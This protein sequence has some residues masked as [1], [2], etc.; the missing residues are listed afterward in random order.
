[1]A[2]TSE[3]L[4][5]ASMEVMFDA[6]EAFTVG[7][8]PL[9]RLQKKLKSQ[10]E[11][12][13]GKKNI[14]KINFCTNGYCTDAVLWL[15]GNTLPM[16]AIATLSEIN[17]LGCGLITDVGISWITKFLRTN[18]HTLIKLDGC[19]KITDA[20]LALLKTA[21][22]LAQISAMATSVTHLRQHGYTKGC[23][24]L[25][26]HESYDRETRRNAQVLIIPYKTQAS[27]AVYLKNQ[28]ITPRQHL[29]RI[30][31]AIVKDWHLNL[32]EIDSVNPLF[33]NL[34]SPNLVQVIIPFDANC[35][36]PEIR[37]HIGDTISLVL[38]KERLNPVHPHLKVQQNNNFF[39]VYMYHKCILT[40]DGI[41][42]SLTNTESVIGMVTSRQPLSRSHPYFEVECLTV[43]SEE[44]TGVVIGVIFDVL[45][46][47]RFPME[48][49]ETN[50][51]AVEGFQL[52]AGV[53]F[54]FGVEGD[55]QSEYV[56]KEDAEFYWTK[57]GV[58]MTEKSVSEKPHIGMYPMLSVLGSQTGEVKILN[59]ASLPEEILADYGRNKQYWSCLF[60][61]NILHD[62]DGILS[63]RDNYASLNDVGLFICNREIT[64]R[65]NSCTIEIL[66]TGT[67]GTITLGIGPEDYKVNRQ[68][69]W[70]SN[71][72]ALH[73]D[74]GQVYRGSGGSSISPPG[75]EF[76]WK[77]GDK[78]T[79]TVTNF[80]GEQIIAS[81]KPTVEFS[82]NGN[83]SPM[84][85]KVTMGRSH[86]INPMDDGLLAYRSFD[87][88][89]FYGL[90]VSKTPISQHLPFF[91]IEVLKCNDRQHIG[92]GLC[93][94]YYPSNEMI[95]WKQGSVGYHAD[96]GKLYH[97]TST[98]YASTITR[99][100]TSYKAGD[101]IRCEVDFMKARVKPDGTLY[102]QQ[103]ISVW[104]YKNGVKTHECDFEYLTEGLY[105]AINLHFEGDQ[106]KLHNYYPG[107]ESQFS[108]LDKEETNAA[109]PKYSF[110]EGCHF[111][112]VGMGSDSADA[113]G[114]IQLISQL[115]NP[116]TD[117]PAISSLQ[118][119]IDQLKCHLGSLDLQAQERY[120]QLLWQLEC[121]QRF[122]KNHQRL[123]FMSLNLSSHEGVNEIKDHIVSHL[124]S[125]LR[126]HTRFYELEETTWKYLDNICSILKEKNILLAEDLHELVPKSSISGN[127]RMFEQAV[128]F[129][130]KKGLVLCLPMKNSLVVLDF[131]FVL[132]LTTS[133]EQCQKKEPSHSVPCIGVGATI[134][135][136]ELQ[137]CE[138]VQELDEHRVRLLRWILQ[139]FGVLRIPSIRVST[140][141]PMYLFF[142]L[143]SIGRTSLT[144]NDFMCHEQDKKNVVVMRR[145]YRFIHTLGKSLFAFILTR[146]ARFSH[147]VLICHDGGVFQ[148]GAVQTLVQRSS[149]ESVNSSIGCVHD[150]HSPVDEDD[151]QTVCTLCNLCCE[152]GSKCPYKGIANRRL[153]QAGCGTKVTGC[154]DCGICKNCADELWTI[155][156]FLRPCC[157][158][159]TH[160]YRRNHTAVPLNST[161]F[162]EV[163]CIN[164]DKKNTVLCLKRET[165]SELLIQVF[166]GPAVEVSSYAVLEKYNEKQDFPQRLHFAEGDT[167]TVKL[168]SLKLSHHQLE[169]EM[170]EEKLEI[171]PVYFTVICRECRVWHDTG[172]VCYNSSLR[173]CPVSQFVGHKPLSP[174]C[175]KFSFEILNEGESRYIAIGL[176]P[177]RYNAN[178]QPGLD[179]CLRLFTGVGWPSVR[180]AE[181]TK[182]DIMGVEL[183]LEEMKASFFKNDQLVHRTE[184]LR[185]PAGGFYPIVGMHSFGEAVRLLQ[186]EPWQPDNEEEVSSLPDA[187]DCYKYGNLWVSPG[188]TIQ[189]TNLKTG[190][191]GWLMLHNPSRN[192]V[193]YQ[194]LP[195][196]I[197]NSIGTLQAGMSTTFYFSL[198][199]ND[200]TPELTVQW[201]QLDSGREYSTEDIQLLHSSAT[202]ETLLTH[203]VTLKMASDFLVDTSPLKRTSDGD[204]DGSARCTLEVFKNGILVDKYWLKGSSY[205]CVLPFETSA[206]L[207]YP[208]FPTLDVP[209]T[210]Y[211]GMRL[212]A[213]PSAYAY[214]ESVVVGVS[215][216]GQNIT[217]EYSVPNAEENVQKEF[218]LSSSV[219]QLKEIPYETIV[220]AKPPETKSDDTDNS[221]VEKKGDHPN[222]KQSEKE[223]R[224]AVEIQGYLPRGNISTTKR[225]YMFV[226][227]HLLT[228]ASQHAIEALDPQ[229]LRN[230]LQSVAICRNVP[231][232]LTV[233]E[234]QIT[235]LSRMPS[236]WVHG[237]NALKQ[238]VGETFAYL[239]SALN[240]EKL[241]YPQMPY[242]FTDIEVHRLCLLVDQLTVTGW[243]ET[244]IDVP[245]HFVDLPP[246]KTHKP[247]PTELLYGS[248]LS[249]WTYTSLVAKQLQLPQCDRIFSGGKPNL[250]RYQLESAMSSLLHIYT[251][252]CHI[253]AEQHGGL[254]Y[255]T[256]FDSG[257]DTVL[258]AIHHGD[259]FVKDTLDAENL[260]NSNMLLRKFF[261][262]GNSFCFVTMC[263]AH[264]L[265]LETGGTALPGVEFQVE[266]F[267][268]Y[269]E[270][271]NVFD[272]I[273]DGLETLPGEFFETFPSLQVFRLEN[274]NKL[275]EIPPNISL[276]KRLEK[277]QLKD[278]PITTLPED[279]FE[280]PDLMVLELVNLPVKVLPDRT[281]ETSWLT[282]LVLSGLQLT[283][284][285]PSVGNLTELVELNLENNLLTDLPMEF[286]KLQR[287][288][289]LNLCGIPWIT[290]EGTRSGLPLD[291]YNEWF[292]SKPYLR[293]F[294]GNDK[295][296]KFF[297][298]CDISRN[299]MLFEEELAALNV[300][301]FWD[302]PRIGSTDINDTEFGGIPPVIFTL[303]SLEELYLDY[304]AI[305][306][307]PVHLCRLQ[308]L[309]V[310]SLAYNPLLESL[311]GSLGHLP[312]LK[313]IRLVSCPSLRT[314][315]NEVVSRGFESIKA[316]LK[317]LAGG[318]TECRRTK[319]MFVGLGGAGKT[320]LLRALMSSGKRTEGTKG[321]DITDGIIIQPWTV[322]T[323]NGVEVTYST[324]DFAGQTLYYNT[325]QFFLS[326]RAVYLLLWSTRQGFEHA[327]LD[328]WL[329]SVA[330]HAPKTPIFVVGTHCDQ[331]PKA[332]IPMEELKARYP[333]IVGF[334]FVSSVAGMGIAELEKDLLRVTLEQKN[335]GEKVPQV[336]LSL[337]Q[338]I[339]AERSTKSILQWEIIKGFSMEVGIYD[340]KDIKEAIQFL[341]ELGTVQYFDNDFL[342]EIIVI[343]PQWIVNVMACVVSV[344][345]SQL[346]KDKGRF[347]HKYIAQIWK[348]YPP[349]LHKWLLQLT[350]EFDLTFPLPK[351]EVNI[352]PCLLP[353]EEP[354]KLIWPSIEGREG[355]KETKMLYDFAYLPTGLFNRAQ[356]RLFQFSD[357]ELTWKRG[358]LLKKNNHLAL[359]KQISNCQLL[360]QVQGPRPENII[361][362]VHEVIESLIE[363]SFYGVV[364]DFLLPCP[365][366]MTKEGTREPSM[367]KGSLVK[368][369]KDHR[370]PFLQ[371]RKFFHTVSM[372][373]LQEVM[374][375]DTATDFDAHLQQSIMALQK[376]NSEM[377]KDV[378]ILYS[379]QD[380]PAKN[381]NDKIHPAWIHADLEKDG[382]KDGYSCWFP[383]N[384]QNISVEDLMMQLKN[385]K[386]VVALVSDNFERDQKSNDMLMYTMD[387][388]KKAYIIVVIRPDMA[389]ENADLGMRIGRQEVMV[390]IK[391]KD[392]YK[393]KVE[394]LL[395][396]VKEK[397]HGI[398]SAIHHPEC[399]ISYCWS[400]SHD[401]QS[402][403]TFCPPGALGW[404]DPRE[405]KKW[406]A[407]HGITCWIDTEQATNGQG[408]FKNITEGM[409][410][411]R[412]LVAFVSDEYVKSDNCMM[413]LR[414]GVLTLNLPLVVCIV[415]TGRDWKE[416][417]VGILMHR[418]KASKVYFQQENPLAHGTLLEYV[419]KIL[420]ENNSHRDQLLITKQKM[421]KKQ[422]QKKTPDKTS[423]NEECELTQRRFMRHIISYVSATDSTP[424]PRLLVVDFERTACLCGS[425]SGSV[426]HLSIFQLLKVEV[427]TQLLDLPHLVQHCG[428]RLH[429]EHARNLRDGICAKHLLA[430]RW[431]KTLNLSSDSC[432]A[433]LARLYAVLQQSSVQLNCFAGPSGKKYH[434]WIEEGAAENPNFVEA[435]STIRS[436][437][438]K[439]LEAESFL[440]QLCRCHLPTGKTQ[441]LCEKH[442]N[443]PRITKLSTESASRDEVRRVL[444][445]EDVQLRELIEKSPIYKKKRAMVSQKKSWQQMRKKAADSTKKVLNK[446]SSNS[447]FNTEKT[448]KQNEPVASTSNAVQ[449]SDATTV[450]SE[451]G[452]SSKKGVDGKSSSKTCSL[453]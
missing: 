6:E 169:E 199:P 423:F 281:P 360:V 344:K 91:E 348:D 43:A 99:E 185:M 290:M 334:H 32:L 25:I 330:S 161:T 419:K 136:N 57:N 398:H 337:E 152:H 172:I 248:M 388:L 206:I 162:D 194:I 137:L 139:F 176:C 341:H 284:V 182:G 392:R 263:K 97:N 64:Q 96:N 365:D 225:A 14:V 138:K 130:Q 15:I 438:R 373:Q 148:S 49:N 302:V 247:L 155:R 326:K 126:H 31:N 387:T 70:D 112:V 22:P 167:V 292:D 16:E 71:S 180:L 39:D 317:R 92:I 62:E 385:C 409:R 188:R 102:P 20:G 435:Y 448:E 332:D 53:R 61:S 175:N 440:Q 273:L 156:S 384:V 198:A 159:A 184:K 434:E 13:S 278:S 361:F 135:E 239:P 265:C 195:S 243:N 293:G 142:T 237:N 441:W 76:V 213:Q 5:A 51:G 370:A 160:K 98:G 151:K 17:L 356:V 416:S 204:P 430:S 232:R 166:P 396:Q 80:S 258:E 274:C 60:S 383:E 277:V 77:K 331:V 250:P 190:R 322:K 157:E 266:N 367:F 297:H 47:A 26:D 451:K 369:A 215:N 404:G 103:K 426:V 431:M 118:A 2:K 121:H 234:Q 288:R 256:F 123:S 355:V 393:S 210:V 253:C 191:A 287:L 439:N 36:I 95:G 109:K 205:I 145:T 405:I 335:M 305:T 301:L 366:C 171:K 129:L 217:L 28:K 374:P 443:G 186:K 219:I 208:K 310:L 42:T 323:D 4:V 244:A 216:D 115:F 280:I 437:L 178:R 122:I 125:D 235:D 371:C 333:Q 40:A 399:F 164:L 29:H 214:M 418:S 223:V 402:K 249:G 146:C 127:G 359:I 262:S 298:D 52:A 295:I 105:P 282:K 238:Q 306:T 338:K 324:W 429:Q 12:Y 117:L 453:Q 351:E 428:Q 209:N 124:E 163:E 452:Q 246:I 261:Y 433:Y 417:E 1:M 45:M 10:C 242:M 346:Q 285:P 197:R 82:V 264:A 336:W 329:S 347:S 352:V 378:V 414:F 78:I 445:E 128:R 294:L 168:D 303:S 114:K 391:T 107:P 442:Q 41:F 270:T 425:S 183:D 179:H 196:K 307:V 85:N 312:S 177:K 56:P 254:E 67:R 37:K 316:Y 202:S 69:G 72:I 173:A 94:A 200:D 403:G 63:Y 421:E 300:H 218:P 86:F 372:A 212:V 251:S 120:S 140:T 19:T 33:E 35:E 154:K 73:G 444:F 84:K 400:N 436:D 321:E 147:V 304:Q 110:T 381:E 54:G 291:K 231:T 101:I 74:N 227:F 449:K 236:S 320:S 233:Q 252:L 328:F 255:Q 318:F 271:I 18:S 349:E 390:M 260:N 27:M 65:H 289:I 7:Y 111:L 23:P 144:L 379:A 339:L 113:K 158:I 193:G 413:E 364:Y 340:E 245:I 327:G 48:S 228:E 149:K 89:D 343:N 380:I 363:E 134:W 38:S 397:L 181:C 368:R 230:S 58:K 11:S 21:C 308:N 170:E 407:S 350:E 447:T 108:Q 427:E 408:L 377:S 68:P 211:K 432:S 207:R 59:F 50:G 9:D 104:F 229:W 315:P 257:T 269:G 55:W 46:G 259:S 395:V 450:N 354:K 286:Q 275:T 279:L 309:A 119:E 283:A 187:F 240:F 313:S 411:S 150:W 88:R 132:D 174:E 394:D 75:G 133:I 226:P 272:R 81:D 357:G 376:F 296:S 66:D 342:R 268:P 192:T 358:S 241:C 116:E 106:V 299:L 222:D 153:R 221:T 8:I 314:P 406:L 131:G 386:L 353:Q 44:G 375:A 345:D 415:G 143:D 276:C 30:Q 100:D 93:H 267:Q 83:V 141:D 422:E 189:L 165:E 401:A 319:L 3:E 24:L 203:R 424:M 412:M 325:H 224:A 410:Q 34:V 420:A 87:Q 201:L 311:P 446:V 362:L 220:K 90:F 389:W 79:A 382:E